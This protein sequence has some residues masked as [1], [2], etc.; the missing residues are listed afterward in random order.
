MITFGALYYL[1]PRLWNRERLYSLSLVSWHFWLATIGI[2]LYAASMWV[3]GI[4][5]GLMWREVDD[6][7]FLVNSFADSVAA[8]HPMYVIRALGG[9]LYL[10]GGVIMAWNLWKTVA[11]RPAA[12][13]GVR[14]AMPTTISPDRRRPKVSPRLPEEIHELPHHSWLH[15]TWS[16]RTPSC[17]SCFSFIVVTVGGLVQIVPL[18]YLD[19]T[20]EKVE[21]MRPYSPLELAG[22]DIYV[23]EGCYVCHSQMI[24]V[25]AR[26]GGALRPLLA[27]GGVDVRPPVP[28]GLQAHRARPRARRR[29]L[30]RRLA[31]G[32]H[33]QPARH[34]ARS[35]S[36]RPIPGSAETPIGAEQHR[37]RHARPARRPACPTPTR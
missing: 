32:A 1:V 25:D 13:R 35:R 3:A 9:V 11:G 20:I 31:R 14:P 2:V 33:A 28:V 6:Q 30:L 23:R 5:Q 29:P 17:C 10:A 26:R 12:R 18:F 8:M 34:G 36:C 37:R 22:R 16:R 24:R 7:G 27:G 21:G 15:H 19:N 4:M